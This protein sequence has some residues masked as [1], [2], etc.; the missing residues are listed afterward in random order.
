MTFDILATSLG[1]HDILWAPISGEKRLV[2]V[3]SQ[4]EADLD[5]DRNQPSR[6]FRP[7]PFLGRP[8]AHSEGKG[9]DGRMDGTVKSYRMVGIPK[10]EL[11]SSNLLTS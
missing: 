1:V 6:F 8:R 9:T 2:R 5:G 7:L 4:D 11:D 10:V 3:W